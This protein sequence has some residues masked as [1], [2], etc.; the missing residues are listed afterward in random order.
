MSEL[1]FTCLLPVC[2]HDD[3]GHFRAALAS[4]FE[5]SI[6]PDRVLICEDG[7]LPET[8][9]RVI[10]DFA[11]DRLER[12]ANPNG[13]GLHN[14]LNAALS[15]VETPWICR[16]DADDVNRPERFAV[17]VEHLRR[18]PELSALGAE[19]EEFGPDGA[20]RRKRMPSSPQ[21]V[22][23]WAAF[24][25][26][27]NHMTAFVRTEAIRAC[28]GYPAIPL[29]EDYALWLAL[30]KA[31]RRLSNVP[32]VLVD[33]RLGEGFYRRR[34]GLRN[35]SSELELFRLK[36]AV[37]GIGLVRAAASLAARA[38]ILSFGPAVTGAVYRTAL[39]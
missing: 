18:H 22:L 24:R 26:P 13:A 32:E 3:P 35:L 37:P 36:R 9:R 39:R 14:N 34:S 8:L 12:S 10:A 23:S 20:T 38:A 21:A 33:A 5:N 19:I 11:C 15:R 27:I 29:K 2:P 25:N 31:G 17:Q 1:S 16:A 6:V 30:L 7:E 28:G 4:V